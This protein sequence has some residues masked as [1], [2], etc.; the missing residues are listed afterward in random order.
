MKNKTIFLILCG[1]SLLTIS[2][3][4]CNHHTKN[5]LMQ[6]YHQEGLI[7]EAISYQNATTN[8]LGTSIILYNVQ[9]K[10]Y[11]HITIHR[12]QL[13]NTKTSYKLYLQGIQGSAIQSL[14]TVFPPDFQKQLAQYTPSKDLLNH[15]ILSW[16]ILGQD[17]MEADIFLNAKRTA[18]NQISVKLII[19]NKGK[20]IMSLSSQ[21]TPHYPNETLLKNL[22][23][24]ALQFSLDDID[25]TLKQTLDDYTLSKEIPFLTETNPILLN[26]F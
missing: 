11:P 4:S 24:H 22:Q 13:E 9:H 17:K 6:Q 14:Q 12:L 16:A 18:P 15:P 23:A 8:A 10:N 1:T 19:Q 3:L 25:T 2:L 21:F 26:L 5:K 20:T 7:T